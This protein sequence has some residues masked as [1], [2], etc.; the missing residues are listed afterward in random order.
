MVAQ[1]KLSTAQLREVLN[2]TQSLLKS[3]RAAIAQYQGEKHTHKATRTGQGAHRDNRVTQ[4]V[5]LHLM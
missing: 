1:M 2:R 4:D 3:H 5:S